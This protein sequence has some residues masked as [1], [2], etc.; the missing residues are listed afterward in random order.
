MIDGI[1]NNGPKE[2]VKDRLK[3][4][5]EKCSAQPVKANDVKKEEICL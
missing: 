5:E 1:I 4:A 3:D 2:S